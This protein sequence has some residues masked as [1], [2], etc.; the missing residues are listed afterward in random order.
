MASHVGLT[1]VTMIVFGGL[2]FGTSVHA[3]Y[4]QAEADLLAVAHE[5]V[6]TLN[7]EKAPA[8]LQI[9]DLYRHRFGMAPRDHAY[10]AV[11][12]ETGQRLYA[13]QRLPEH[14]RPS[15]ILPPV[16]G[17]HPFRTRASGRYFDVIVATPSGGQ[18]LIGR[19]LAKEWD[20]LQWL[21]IRIM[22]LG[23]LCIVGGALASNAIARRLAKPLTNLA[24]TAER[25]TSR[26]LHQRIEPADG[27]QEVIRLVEVFN[28]MLSG[29]ETSFAKQARFIADAS[30]ELRTP[31]A[32]VLSQVE[33]TLYRER[34]PEDYRQALGVC[35]ESSKRMK[36]LIESLLF[37]ARADAGR[38]IMR[39][40]PTNLA[41]IAAQAVGSLQPLASDH[42]I[43]FETD[44]SD[45]PLNADPDRLGQVVTN[46]ITNAVRYNEPGGYVSIRTRMHGDRRVLTVQ[47]NGIGIP[48]TDQ[49]YLF[50]RFYRVDSA[51]THNDEAGTGLGLSLVQ[52]IVMA[53]GGTIKL[54]SEPGT[55]TTITIDLPEDF[56]E[57]R[58]EIE[59]SDP[60]K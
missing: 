49:P 14:A 30:H 24:T 60:P 5:L 36:G 52:E 12:D 20:A 47:D 59:R 26:R 7:S 28:R 53:H 34:S 25:I 31:V 2:L 51:R 44:L 37:L 50:D 41:A 58:A 56:K 4:R 23:I 17:P 46:L 22:V 39:P 6:G 3:T 43:R 29:L 15:S 38:L 11:W 55:G 57:G 19:P 8:Q 21:A 40:Q 27:S 13:S 32:V 16:K 45:A 33:H 48:A 54:C 9:S 10:V 18:L 1:F 35:L 42:S